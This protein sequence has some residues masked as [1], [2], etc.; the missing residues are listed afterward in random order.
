MQSKDQ[1]LGENQGYRS[2]K[3]RNTDQEATT[4]NRVQ[5]TYLCSSQ[6]WGADQ[7][8]AGEHRVQTKKARRSST[9][10]LRTLQALWA[11]IK[12]FEKRWGTDQNVKRQKRK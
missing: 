1:R 10:S 5:I 2:D 8:N 9:F 6:K 12:E 11:Q 7:E 4:K 3:Q